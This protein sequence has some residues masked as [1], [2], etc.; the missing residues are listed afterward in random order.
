MYGPITVR[1]KG[2][3]TAGEQR[4]TAGTMGTDPAKA[5]ET[6]KKNAGRRQKCG[7]PG[8]PGLERKQPDFFRSWE[9][10]P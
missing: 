10:G 2:A 6:E 4:Q 5:R 7:G 9:D 1:D 3:E 8:Q